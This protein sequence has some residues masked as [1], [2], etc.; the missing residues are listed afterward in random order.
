MT[1]DEVE[2]FTMKL[3]DGTS[4]AAVDVGCINLDAEELYLGGERLTEARAEALADEAERRGGP[5]ASG[6]DRAAKIDR[7]LTEVDTDHAET[8]R[9]LEDR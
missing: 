3:P 7:W 1:N 4:V 6:E 5:S 8:L 9:K 2:V